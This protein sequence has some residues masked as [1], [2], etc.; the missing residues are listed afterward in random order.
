[1]SSKE[2]KKKG[3]EYLE[4][5]KEKYDVIGQD[6]YDYLEGL[7]Q[8]KG[9]SYWDYVHVDSLLG[10][11]VP[12]TDYPDEIIFIT[13]HQICELYFKLVKQELSLLTDKKGKEFLDVK[14]WHKRIARVNNYFKHLCSSF[15][16]MKS[17]M[18]RMEFTKFRMA[19]LPASGFQG[20][21]F[22]HIE[23]MSTNLNSLLDEE[24]RVKRDMPLEKLYG[25]IYWKKGGIDLKSERKTLTLLEFE[26]KYN[27]E[28]LL[29][30]KEYKFKNLA[31]LYYKAD[32]EIKQDEKLKELLRAYDRW[33]NVFWKLSHLMASSRHLPKDDTGTGGTNW[34]AYL[35]PKSKYQRI[36]FFQT[37][38]SETEKEEWGKMGVQ[39][40]FKEQ[41][42]SQW[43][44]PEA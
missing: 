13:Y 1:M 3:Q 30:I 2:E 14:N 29:L 34:R 28:F 33:V 41:V 11:Q 42:E 18:D 26:K 36:I 35:P 37:L 23:F 39:K 5:L 32:N 24:G 19:L 15:D 40:H 38:W 44:K 8:S 17:G 27:D 25:H 16:I 4:K 10:L 21:Q 7:V 9:L 43:L 22:R 20:A 31:Y 12:R 6:F